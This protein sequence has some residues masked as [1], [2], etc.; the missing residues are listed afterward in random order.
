MAPSPRKGLALAVGAL[1]RPGRARLA[2]HAVLAGPQ[3]SASGPLP[4]HHTLLGPELED[5]LRGETWLVGV[6]ASPPPL[7]THRSKA[8]GPK[9][10]P[11]WQ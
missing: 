1:G 11:S 10:W 4:T 6:V 3:D 8:Q 7:A 2:E 5:H 9:A